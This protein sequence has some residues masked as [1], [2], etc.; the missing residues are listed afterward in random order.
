MKNGFL[1]WKIFAI[2]IFPSPSSYYWFYM[3]WMQ[4]SD[5]N[6]YS[7][8]FLRIVEKKWFF[9]I[10]CKLGQLFTQVQLIFL[11]TKYP[12]SYRTGT[13]KYSAGNATD[14][15]SLANCLQ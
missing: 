10:F 14:K 3:Q 1:S 12:V 11:L 4:V 8:Y 6:K 15:K 9:N 7:I 2:N 13:L 5:E